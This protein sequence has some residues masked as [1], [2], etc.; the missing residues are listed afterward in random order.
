MSTHEVIKMYR[1]AKDKAKQLKILAEMNECSV[2]D[3]VYILISSGKYSED[4]FTEYI[5]KSGTPPWIL[6]LKEIVE[7]IEE[8]EV[9]KRAIET[10]IMAVKEAIR[11]SVFRE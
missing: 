4:E 7:Y 6:P 8:L 10:E 5:G 9:K 11:D 3:I 1:D 2:R